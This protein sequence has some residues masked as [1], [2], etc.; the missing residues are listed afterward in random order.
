MPMNILKTNLSRRSI[1]TTVDDEMESFVR[2]VGRVP[3]HENTKLNA[4]YALGEMED[5]N[6]SDD[7]DE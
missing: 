2:W 5:L 4:M 7:D 1:R 6:L 3:Y